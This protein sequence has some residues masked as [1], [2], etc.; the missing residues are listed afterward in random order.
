MYSLDEKMEVINYLLT[1]DVS[2][3]QAEKKYGINRETIRGWLSK[4]KRGGINKLKKKEKY[5]KYTGQ[6]KVD[7]VEYMY[8][9]RCSRKKTSMV[10]M[11]SDYLVKEWDLVY[12]YEGKDVL[13][14]GNYMKTVKKKHQNPN[15]KSK[16]ELLEEIE[17]LRMENAYLKKLRALIQKETKPNNGKK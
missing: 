14:K 1:N 5:Q 16:E 2:L 17:Q 9:H 11:I 6:F 10:F 15:E 7:V 12:R 4:Y 3:C 13:L 8:E